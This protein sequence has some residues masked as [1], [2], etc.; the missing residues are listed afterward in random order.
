MP[1]AAMQ[2][3]DISSEDPVA[4]FLSP[5]AEQERVN[6][7]I[8][9][10]GG[11]VDTGPDGIG[12]D[13]SNLETGYG[14]DGFKYNAALDMS[15]QSL[16]LQDVLNNE[17]ALE[18]LTEDEIV[19]L[20]E[21]LDTVQV[22]QSTLQQV[23][24][25]ELNIGDA[26]RS[27]LRQVSLQLGNLHSI[28]ATLANS[29]RQWTMNENRDM[30]GG[31]LQQMVADNFAARQAEYARVNI[32]DKVLQNGGDTPVA[33]TLTGMKGFETGPEE[34]KFDPELEARINS[35]PQTSFTM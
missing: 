23:L 19:K 9:A 31:S 34:P 24:N 26:D 21:E 4:S 32:G 6:A 1:E 18:D 28:P 5:S 16:V 15:G 22:F 27:A 29:M 11:L 33:E 17:K 2:M 25:G 13:G 20:D 8:A 14:R 30:N 3:P 10:E 12:Q 35:G 7:E